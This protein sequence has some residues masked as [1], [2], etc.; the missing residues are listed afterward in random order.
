MQIVIFTMV[1]ERTLMTYPEI[2]REDFMALLLNDDAA[3][4]VPKETV[5]TF[6]D[7]DIE[8]C[9]NLGTIVKPEKSFFS[10]LGFVFC[11]IYICWGTV[12][13]KRSYL[14]R[15]MNLGLVACNICH[16]KRLFNAVKCDEKRTLEHYLGK[17]VNRWGYE[18]YPGEHLYPLSAG[19]WFSPS[20]SGVRV[21]LLYIPD[22]C[23]T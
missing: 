10:E 9:T 8:M 22:S 19:G 1:R 16:A 6:I 12:D 2:P 3:V 7:I 5:D 21:D 17:L 11:E 20:D 14:Y 15:E 13:K 23:Q 4:A 18:F